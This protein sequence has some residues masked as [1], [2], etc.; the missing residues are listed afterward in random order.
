MLRT[1][2]CAVLALLMVTGLVMAQGKGKKNKPVTGKVTK[3]EGDTLT[4]SVK[5]KKETS[6][7]TFTLT[8]DTKFASNEGGEKKDLSATDA[9]AKLKAGTTVQVQADETGKVQTLTFGTAKKKN[10]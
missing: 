1:F 6:D 10:K 5:V 2:F 4:V 7:K 3:L 8:P 9:R